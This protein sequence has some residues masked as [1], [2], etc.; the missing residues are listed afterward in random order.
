MSTKQPGKIICIRLFPELGQYV[1]EIHL[2]DY[3]PQLGPSRGRNV[4]IGD[5]DAPLKPFCEH[6]VKWGYNGIVTPEVNPRHLRQKGALQLLC[7]KMGELF[8]Q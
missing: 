1:Q 3:K 8:Q 5:G 7:Q 6:I 2:C 4:F